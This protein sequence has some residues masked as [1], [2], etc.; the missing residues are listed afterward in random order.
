MVEHHVRNVGV[1]SSNLFFSTSFKETMNPAYGVFMRKLIL[2]SVVLAA[3]LLF[4]Q[5]KKEYSCSLK[6]DNPKVES[7][8]SEAGGSKTGRN[9]STTITT[10]RTMH[11]HAKASFR[12][13]EFPTGIRLN[14]LFTGRTDEGQAIVLS[15][16]TVEVK[17]NEKGDFETDFVSSP[18]VWVEKKTR[19]G[20]RRNR[21]TKTD[22]SGTRLGF[23]VI[24][25]VVGD[26]VERAWT[27]KP[28]WQK[29]AEKYP[30][31]ESEL[32]KLK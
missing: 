32:L 28:S 4:A 15:K 21:G 29:L 27:S 7:K 23:C 18:A 25:L 30:L 12:G 20:G 10:S 13:K 16:N 11:C 26:K 9:S 5:E 19:V 6:V 2:T 1:E 8:K 24:Q 14:C 17:L 31:P 22:A 3:S